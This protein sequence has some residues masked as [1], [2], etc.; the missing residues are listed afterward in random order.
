[1]VAKA[2]ADDMKAAGYNVETPV[3]TSAELSVEG[4]ANGKFAFGTS[5][6]STALVAIEAGGDLQLFIDNIANEWSLYATN[7]I[8][9]CADLS[10]QPVGIFSEG[11]VSTAMVRNYFATECPDAKPEYLVLGDSQT[12]AAALV[13]GQIKATPVELSDALNLEATSTDKVHRLASFAES[14]PDLKTTSFYGNTTFMKANPE[15]TRAFTKALL[16]VYRRIDGDPGYLKEL[17]LKYYPEVG[18]DTLDA[19]V[20]E[21][22]DGH[23]FPVNGGLTDDNLAYSIKFFQDAGVLKSAISPTDAADLSYMNAVLDEI[24]RK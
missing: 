8:N 24:G 6:N 12:R 16:E 10:G 3:M 5:G 21:Y 15:T 20:K 19:A 22:A 14:L 1:M 23:Y 4:V 18:K 7:D 2:A 13:A 9:A 17:T 11:G